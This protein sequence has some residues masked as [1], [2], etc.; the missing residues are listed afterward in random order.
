[1]NYYLEFLIITLERKFFTK[2]FTCPQVCFEITDLLK[3]YY[4]K[5]P[6]NGIIQIES[7]EFNPSGNFYIV[8]KKNNTV[9]V[10]HFT[11]G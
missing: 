9:A 2:N 8:D 6:K 10:D 5:I 3:N 11:G 4:G 7:S 1:M